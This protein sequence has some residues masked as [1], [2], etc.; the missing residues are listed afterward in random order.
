MQG[1][2]GSG[3]VMPRGIP[4]CSHQQFWS[5]T[6]E[7]PVGKWR[8]IVDLSLPEGGFV[9]DGIRESWCSLTYATVDN[10]VRGIVNRSWLRNFLIKV[11]ICNAYRVVQI[12]PDDRWLMGMLWDRSLFVY[13][14][15]PFGLRSAPKIFTALLDA[16][17]CC[18]VD[19]V[20]ARYQLR[21]SL[22]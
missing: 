5:D 14:A 19:S 6:K 13:T 11:D 9:N 7:Y 21:D 8:L 3:S 15:L 20:V 10:A 16:A 1:R 22:S 12:H 18:W 2:K 4:L 17:G